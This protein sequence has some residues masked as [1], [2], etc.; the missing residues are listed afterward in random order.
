MC[1]KIYLERKK[2]GGAVFLF[3]NIYISREK[4]RKKKNYKMTK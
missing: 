3:K 2:V 1:Y 4:E